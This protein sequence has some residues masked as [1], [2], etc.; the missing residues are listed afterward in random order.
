MKALYTT[1]YI[2]SLTLITLLTVSCAALPRSASVVL[3]GTNNTNDLAIRIT[4]PNQGSALPIVLFSHGAYSSKDSYNALVD[5]W[6]QAGFIVIAP[7]HRDSVTLGVKRG[8]N[9]PRYFQWRLDD[10]SS[11]LGHLPEVL[12]NVPGLI[13]RADITRVA[14]TGHSF[15]GLVAQTLAGASYFDTA[16]QNTVLQSDARIRAVIIFSG[17][18]PFPPLL[19]PE[20]FAALKTPTLVTVGTDDLKQAPD[21]SGYEWRRKPYDLIAPND[22]YRLT[23]NG[24]DHYLGG[25]V[26]RD[27]LP[28]SPKAEQFVAVFND[29]STFFLKAYLKDDPHALRELKNT[30]VKREIFNKK[31]NIG[32]LESR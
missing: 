32:T 15:G 3:Q 22:K 2:I 27:D 7:T 5:H 23:L 18:G 21:M 1:R 9:E 13:A 31:L 4:Y 16:Q 29:Y 25:A 11:L 6:A 24:A 30:A 19:R 26:G 17:P 8:T 20:D 14:S 10:M 28:R 12:S